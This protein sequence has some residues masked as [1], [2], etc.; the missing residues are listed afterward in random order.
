MKVTVVG[1]G[2]VGATVANV[3]AMKNFASEL[4]LLDIKEGVSEGKAMDMMQT[5]HMLNIDTKITGVTNDYKA[6]AGSKVV[7]I[8]SGIP[9]KPGMSREDLIGTNAKIVKSVV[10][11]AL[12]Y[13]PEAIF[14]IISNPMDAMTYLTLKDSKLPRERIIGQGGYGFIYLAQDQRL[15][16]RKC[17]VKQVIYDPT[18]PPAM[19]QE[20]RDQFMREATVLARLD[21]P[22]LPKVSDFFS[23]EDNDFL[24][25]D[26]VPGDDLRALLAKAENSGK[27][28]P[29]SEVLGWAV[30]IGDALTYLHNQDPPILHRD[31]K[32][33]NIKLTPSGL[34]KLVDFGLVKLL[35][36][37]EVTITILQGQ[38]T[39]L[40]TPLEQYGGESSH[41]DAR[42]DIYAF[43]CTLYHLLTNTPPANVRDRFLNPESLAA[44]RMLNPA[45]S[46]K[47]EEAI[48]WGMALHPNDRPKDVREFIK[49]LTG[50]STSRLRQLSSRSS[51]S[52]N[53]QLGSAE[54][55]LAWIAAGL[56]FLSLFLTIIHN[57]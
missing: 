28:L 32:P 4:V 3:V 5:A 10:D 42:A 51:S 56:T 16:G 57:L 37:G 36:P 19:L 31:I 38:G 41:T 47:V 30:Q 12:E 21:H 40:Y 39:A 55:R 53:G 6:T 26:Y 8:T 45:I 22:N 15:A 23:I 44:P 14:I 29:E 2:N 17:A 11:Q 33:S 9:R 46:P 43:A 25:M 20:A 54:I 50:E 24:V 1:A 34:V 52:N 13:S 7:I 27:F 35:A 48:L 18:F 49:A